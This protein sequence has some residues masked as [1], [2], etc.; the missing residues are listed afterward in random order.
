MATTEI[1]AV[2]LPTGVVPQP[3]SGTSQ[4]VLELMKQQ[5]VQPFSS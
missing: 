5:A 2:Q 3:Q 1:P 4:D